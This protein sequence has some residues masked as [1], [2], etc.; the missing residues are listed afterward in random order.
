VVADLALGRPLHAE[1]WLWLL[2]RE[3]FVDA[4]VERHEGPPASYAIVARRPARV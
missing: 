1:T 3:G 4:S 2:A